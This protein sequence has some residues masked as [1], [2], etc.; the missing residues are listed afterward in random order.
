[1]RACTC[2]YVCLKCLGIDTPSDEKKTEESKREGEEGVEGVGVEGERRG[3]EMEGVGVEGEKGGEEEG[4]EGERGGEGVEVCNGEV[5]D[6]STEGSQSP[7][8]AMETSHSQGEAHVEDGVNPEDEVAMETD[9]QISRANPATSGSDVVHCEGVK[10][11]SVMCEG[12]KVKE[13][14]S[15]TGIAGNSNNNSNKKSGGDDES[16]GEGEGGGG[17]VGEVGEGERVENRRRSLRSLS[18]KKVNKSVKV[19]L[20][21]WVVGFKGQLYMLRVE[22]L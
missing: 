1:M 16:G 22:S 11:D 2:V 14:I 7:P 4:V 21:L 13:V 12:V 20:L 3:E 8:V 5:E 10:G 6:S 15:V 19:S 18:K 9:T 17:E